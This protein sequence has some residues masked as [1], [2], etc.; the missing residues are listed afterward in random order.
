MPSLEPRVE[1]RL[2]SHLINQH[3]NPRRI[4]KSP[5]LELGS[6]SQLN[7]ATKISESQAVAD[8]FASNGMPYC[9]PKLPGYLSLVVCIEEPQFPTHLPRQPYLK[10]RVVAVYSLEQMREMSARKGF[11]NIK[12]LHW[13]VLTIPKQTQ[14]HLLRR[15][16]LEDGLIITTPEAMS[17]L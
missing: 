3:H 12:D 17:R 14:K 1:Y 11:P 16:L 13:R 15:V 8:C 7:V 5:P 4:E 10:Q 9:Y 6:V 2:Q